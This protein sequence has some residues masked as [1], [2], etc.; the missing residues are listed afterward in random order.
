[1][2]IYKLITPLGKKNNWPI[3]P[4]TISLENKDKNSSHKTPLAISLGKK[5]KTATP[6]IEPVTDE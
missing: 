1:V 3:T 6:R 5:T 4:L 2:Y